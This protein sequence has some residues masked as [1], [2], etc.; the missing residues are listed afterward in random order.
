VSERANTQ[1]SA[2][3]EKRAVRIESAMPK[4]RFKSTTKG[5]DLQW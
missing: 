4:K 3:D 1:E 5:G 2:K